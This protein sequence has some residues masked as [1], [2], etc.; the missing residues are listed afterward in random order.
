MD[1]IFKGIH[2]KDEALES[3]QSA[4]DLFQE[5]YKISQFREMHLSVILVD[6]QG[7]NVELVDNESDHV[8]RFFEVYRPGFEMESRQ[9]QPF[10]QVVVDNTQKP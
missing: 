10:L 1:I 9:G 2:T 8:Y 6:E 3:I 4:L 7:D 5:R